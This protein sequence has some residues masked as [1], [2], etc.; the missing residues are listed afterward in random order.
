MPQV[1]CTGRP[2]LCVGN[3][4]GAVSSVNRETVEETLTLLYTTVRV[5]T[6][7][8]RRVIISVSFHSIS[9]D[10]RIN[11]DNCVIGIGAFIAGFGTWLDRHSHNFV[12]NLY[13][14]STLRLWEPGGSCGVFFARG[15]LHRL[16]RQWTSGCPS[17]R[18]SPS[19]LAIAV[20]NK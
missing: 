6:F 16:C 10:F 15:E 9:D 17:S 12:V 7:L 18:S 13:P 2:P 20:R 8:L 14:L 11:P 19:W 1:L 5:C 3:G 4:L